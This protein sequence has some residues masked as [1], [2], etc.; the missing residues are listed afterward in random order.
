MANDDELRET[1]LKRRDLHRGRLIA[2]HEDR[3]R[4]ANGHEASR[5][6][7]DHP[8][9]VAIVALD[10]E[11][12]VVLVRQWRHAASRA[13]W[14]LPAGTRDRDG[15]EPAATAERELAEEAGL[16]ADSWRD[17]GSAPLAPGYSSEVMHFFAATGLRQEQGEPDDD[18]LVR[19]GRFTRDEVADLIS[20]GETDVKTI[21]GLALAGWTM[22]R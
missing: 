2:L 18:E 15:E 13:T 12:R 9:A 1:L 5:E 6:V 10:E 20:D 19:V 3:V 11:G 14:E 8:G 7:I 17:L 22:E 21:A 4:L 16:G